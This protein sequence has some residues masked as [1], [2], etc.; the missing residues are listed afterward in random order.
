MAFS[1][2]SFLALYRHSRPGV[3]PGVPTP[4]VL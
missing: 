2:V 3:R 4:A 1:S